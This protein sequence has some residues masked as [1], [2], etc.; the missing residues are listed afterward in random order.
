MHVLFGFV[1]TKPEVPLLFK[2][3]CKIRDFFPRVPTAKTLEEQKY[4]LSV[5]S[6]VL[7]SKNDHLYESSKEDSR[8]LYQ[9]YDINFCGPD[10]ASISPYYFGINHL[11]SFNKT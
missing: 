10:Q 2:G 11:S 8:I 1:H 7:I 6:L 3:S 4:L 5:Y 9:N